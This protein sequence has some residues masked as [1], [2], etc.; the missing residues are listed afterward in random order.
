MSHTSP[1]TVLI[2]G[3]STGI[4]YELAKLFARDRYNLVLVARNR[5]KLE[6][7][8]S[9]L[10]KEYQVNTTVIA[11]DLSLTDSPQELYD[12]INNQGIE[13]DILI[14]NA[15]FGAYGAFA[16][17]D[18]AR[19]ARMS[20]LNMISLAHLTKLFL[21]SMLE[22]GRGKIMNVASTAAFLPGPFMALYYASKAFVLSFS[23]A[24][25]KELEGSGITVTALCPGATETEFSKRA[26]ME[27][28]RLFASNLIVMM[29]A[30]EVARQGY[31]GFM[32][33]KPVIVTGLSNKVMTLGIRFSPRSWVLGLVHWIMSKR[34]G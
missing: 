15:G 13:I 28:A 11:K 31:V 21:P 14:N 19:E 26:K 16:E 29:S 20:Q 27:K 4:G 18:W 33:G 10:Q 6:E 23:E 24:L 3:A 34:E 5:Q 2:T 12:E 8:A 30:A 22:K 17:T 1:Q 7:L 9:L 25:N 32:K